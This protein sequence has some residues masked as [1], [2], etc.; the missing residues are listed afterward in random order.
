MQSDGAKPPAWF[1]KAMLFAIEEINRNSHL[2]PNTS[3]GIEVYNVGYAEVKVLESVFHWFTDLSFLSPNYFCRKDSK[4]AALLTG[5]SG[6]TSELMGTLLHLYKFPQV[7]ESGMLGRRVSSHIITV[8][9]IK[10]KGFNYS[11]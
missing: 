8:C 10:V 4:S 7:S 2:L 3:L 1:F 6:K 11:L 5:T 9:K